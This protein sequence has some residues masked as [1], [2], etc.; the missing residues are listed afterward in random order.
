MKLSS[1]KLLKRQINNKLKFKKQFLIKS[2]DRFSKHHTLMLQARFSF[3]LSNLH[4]HG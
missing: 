4:L 2:T 1:Q 3:P